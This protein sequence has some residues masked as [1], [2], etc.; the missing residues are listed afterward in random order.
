MDTAVQKIM[1]M[2]D[3]DISDSPGIR[4]NTGA[5]VRTAITAAPRTSSKTMAARNGITAA[6][7]EVT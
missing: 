7:A 3:V 1:E 2:K 5:S 6:A 4:T